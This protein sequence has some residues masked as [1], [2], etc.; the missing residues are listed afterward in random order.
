MIGVGVKARFA[1]H[2]LLDRKNRGGYDLKQPDC[3][4]AVLGAVLDV[5]GSPV[6]PWRPA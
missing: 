5:S 1:K 3:M 6:E 2:W 4:M